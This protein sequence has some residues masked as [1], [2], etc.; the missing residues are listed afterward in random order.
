MIDKG[1][2][3][4]FELTFGKLV[5]PLAGKR[6]VAPEFGLGKILLWRQARFRGVRCGC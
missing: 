5:F 6:A 2:E 3:G 4:S 1:L